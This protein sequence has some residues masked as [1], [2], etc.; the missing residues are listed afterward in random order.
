LTEAEY[1]IFL[2]ND[3]GYIK[4]DEFA[5]LSN[6]HNEAAKTLQGLIAWLEKQ[7]AAGKVTKKDLHST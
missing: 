1:Y 5:S 2:A 4:A 3:L 6:L 7:M